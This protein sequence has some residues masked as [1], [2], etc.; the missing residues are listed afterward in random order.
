[1]EEHPFE[2]L[3]MDILDK[4][5]TFERTLTVE[6][7]EAKLISKQVAPHDVQWVLQNPKDEAA[8]DNEVPVTVLGVLK[9]QEKDNTVKI[10]EQLHRLF[11]SMSHV[12]QQRRNFCLLREWLG[13]RP[14]RI[15]C[16]AYDTRGDDNK[17][18]VGAIKTFEK[19]DLHTS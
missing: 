16:Q 2:R 1:M 19:Y 7:V 18:L 17:W 14:W 8:A 10:E 15:M 13:H 6:H 4:Q 9:E 12:N 11:A 3:L 5:N